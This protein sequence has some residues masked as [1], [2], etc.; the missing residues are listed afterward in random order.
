MDTTSYS[1]NYVKSFSE[2]NQLGA[3]N[4]LIA[5]PPLAIYPSMSFQYKN[6]T[7]GKVNLGYTALAHGPYS[8]TGY[9]VYN[10]S[11][12]NTCSSYYVVKCPTDERIQELGVGTPS[13]SPQPTSISPPL[14]QALHQLQISV[15]ID[16]S[17]KMCQSFQ[18]YIHSMGL[19]SAFTFFDINQPD[20]RAQMMSQ[21]GGE[22]TIPFF[23]S[24]ATGRTYAGPPPSLPQLVERLQ[25][26]SLSYG[27]GVPM[28]E[29]Y[30]WQNEA[31]K[32]K[33]L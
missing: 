2:Y 14:V 27:T 15:Y 6:V 17:H 18:H 21:S 26:S 29:G 28:K 32:K 24:G 5:S 12:P 20:V 1:N 10:E 22:M 30:E 3:P 11:Y 19:Q 4:P 13:P 9:G 23:F 33:S 7:D 16:P 25:S 8:G 31:V